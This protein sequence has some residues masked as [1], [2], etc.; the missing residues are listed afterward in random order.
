M[1]P[2]LEALVQATEAQ[3]AAKRAMLAELLVQGATL[4]RR[5]AR[6]AGF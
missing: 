2:E 4:E 3:L 1:I 6:Y 5:I